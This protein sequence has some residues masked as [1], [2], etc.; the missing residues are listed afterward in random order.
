MVSCLQ[1]A[2]GWDGMPHTGVLATEGG[3]SQLNIIIGA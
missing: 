1:N 2:Q 3:K